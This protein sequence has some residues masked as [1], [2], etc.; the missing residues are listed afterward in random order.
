LVFVSKPITIANSHALATHVAEARDT[1]AQRV[2]CENQA[3]AGAPRSA[4]RGSHQVSVAIDQTRRVRSR[5]VVCWK[6]S[7]RGHLRRE[8]PSTDP[9][10]SSNQGNEQGAEENLASVRNLACKNCW[11]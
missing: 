10:A 3:V 4:G 1:D 6:C 11:K 8:C 2:G 5:G 7:G 9:S